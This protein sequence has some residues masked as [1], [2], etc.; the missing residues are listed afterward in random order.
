LGDGAV[1]E[2][3]DEEE[4]DSNDEDYRG[5][6]YPEDED[7]DEDSC[8]ESNDFRSRPV[9]V[10]RHDFNDDHEYDYDPTYSGIIAQGSLDYDSTC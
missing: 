4:D 7:D 9:T 1:D 5:N 2:H 8:D 3:I 10:H 6:D